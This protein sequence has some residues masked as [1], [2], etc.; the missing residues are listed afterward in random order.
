MNKNVRDF[1][2]SYESPR[3]YLDNYFGE[4]RNNVDVQAELQ[5]IKHHENLDMHN[6]INKTRQTLIERINLYED[7]CLKNLSFHRDSISQIS[8]RISHFIRLE[9][10]G[11]ARLMENIFFEFKKALFTNKVLHFLQNKNADFVISDEHFG[12][13][14][15]I[16]KLLS[17]KCLDFLF[18]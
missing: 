7:E 17:E 6:K 9:S 3:L 12:K 5:I 14:V 15:C 4:T 18:R 16:D 1:K 10:N 11:D 2:L 8:K 13:I